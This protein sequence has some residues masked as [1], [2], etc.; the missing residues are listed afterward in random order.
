MLLKKLRPKLG[1]FFRSKNCFPFEAR[2]K[3]VESAFLSIIDYGDL[4]YMHAATTLLRK[5]DCV[6][7]AAL[8]FVSGAESRTHHCILYDSLAWSSLHQRRKLHMY[9]F[10]AKA[11][12]GKLPSYISNL[13]I[14]YT[15]TYQTRSSSRLRL[16]VPR[17]LSEFG[18][19][20]FSFYAPWTWN[21]LQNVLKLDA[22]PTL[23][24]LKRLLLNALKEN[25]NCFP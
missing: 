11:L 18:K 16:K 2:K 21:E 4:L 3:L 19:S 10:I 1:F 5:L 15:N 14:Y 23:T 12:L 13:L 7:H 6:Y 9:L 25:C 22:L 8:R 20:A 24:S 17:V